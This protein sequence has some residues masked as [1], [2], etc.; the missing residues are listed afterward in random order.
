METHIR[1]SGESERVV[2]EVQ[3]EK[4]FSSC[5]KTLEYIITEYGKNKS[6]AGEVSER[7]A[8]DLDKVL[9]R[10]RLG[11]NTADINSQIIVE[12]LNAIA[13]QFDVRPMTT[14]YGATTVFEVSRDFVKGK[15]AKYKQNRDQK[16]HK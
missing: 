4:G 9:T 13:Y 2:Q 16:R 3:K 12:M 10:I 6:I 11:T 8:A 7:V 14:E 15:I 1:L 5:N